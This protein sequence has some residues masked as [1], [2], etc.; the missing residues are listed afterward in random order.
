MDFNVEDIEKAMEYLE[1]FLYNEGKL[2]EKKAE[3]IYNTLQ[4][5]LE[6]INE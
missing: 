2:T 6:I 3:M 5:I 4:D 1:D